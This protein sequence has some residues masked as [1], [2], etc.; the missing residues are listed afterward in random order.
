MFIAAINEENNQ[1]INI[2][3]QLNKEMGRVPDVGRY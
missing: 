3:N 2:K 1:A